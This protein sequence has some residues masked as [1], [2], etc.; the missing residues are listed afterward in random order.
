MK[1]EPRRSARIKAAEKL[2]SDTESPPANIRN[3]RAKKGTK[4]P[5]VREVSAK[6]STGVAVEHY[7]NPVR[8]CTRK[9]L[10]LR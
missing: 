2:V 8:S 6:S 3:N 4:G 9:D 5:S 10:S 7:D 1:G